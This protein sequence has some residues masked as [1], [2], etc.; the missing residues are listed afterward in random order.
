MLVIDESFDMWNYGK[1]PYDNHLYF[2]DWWQRDMESMIVRDR[3]HPS[4][5]MWSIGN[6]IPESGSSLGAETARKLAGFVRQLDSTRGVTAAVNGL[7]PDKEAFFSGLDVCG[8]NYAV[9][10]YPDGLY[11]R[12]HQWVPGRIMF[13]TESYPLDAFSAWMEVEDHPYVIGD[14]VWTGWDYIGE[15]G[16][17]WLGYPQNHN[18][19]PWNLAFCGDIDIC[20]WK[21]PQSYYRDVLWKRDQLS[22]FIK[23]PAPSFK[24]NARKEDW[25]RWNWVDAVAEW[26]WKGYEG[27][28]LEVSVYSSCERVELFLNGRSL[29]VKT[30][31]RSTRFIA[32]FSVPYQAGELKAVGYRGSGMVQRAV[33]VTAGVPERITL[34]ADRSQLIADGQDLSYITVALTDTKGNINPAA[35][36][37]LH[38]DVSGEAKIV[39]VGNGNPMSLESFQGSSRKAWK[40]KCLVI[41]KAGW[42]GGRIVLRVSG[43]GLEEAQIAIEVR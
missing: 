5:I 13:G 35:E 8:Y 16:I 11:A 43:E 31:D 33:L 14:F 17:G 1:N 28:P 19:F 37:L 22:I 30:T 2:K 15:A 29:G 20:G 4:I 3:N 18:F 10:G 32:T 25:S 7:G 34:K 24:E 39:G 40:G 26:N 23:P 12:D 27:K 42:Q 38:F 21:R 36:N 41:V 6:E 9:G